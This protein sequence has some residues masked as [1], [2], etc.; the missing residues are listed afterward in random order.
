MRNFQVKPTSCYHYLKTWE[1]LWKKIVTQDMLD[2]DIF[3]KHEQTWDVTSKDERL[4]LASE[5]KFIDRDVKCVF[6]TTAKILSK[7]HIL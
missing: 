7:L 5:K 6:N 2:F 4:G 1:K 3:D